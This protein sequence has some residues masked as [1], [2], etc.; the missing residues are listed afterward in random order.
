MV[1]PAARFLGAFAILAAVLLI[2]T[3][4][5]ALNQP[6]PPQPPMPNPNGYDDFVKAGQ[7]LA[8]LK[9]N[10][11]YNTMGQD[12]LR[13]VVAANSE[14]LKLA[15]T[16]LSRECRFPLE[17]STTNNISLS[18]LK[19][20][21]QAF[22]A[23]GRLAQLENR[24]GDAAKSY[25]DTMRLGCQ[26]SR[27]GRLIEALVSVAI[28]AIGATHLEKLVF[29]LDAKQCREAAAALEVAD[30]QRAATA[31]LLDQE[32]EWARRTYGIKGQVMRLVSYKSVKQ[33]EKGCATKIATQQARTWQLMI[34]LAARAYELDR[35]QR[36]KTI[37]EL[38]PAY[39]K[40]I[41]FNPV[42]GT[43]MVYRP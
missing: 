25:S 18:A 10:Q 16:G 21:A 12:E 43:N 20:L 9:S 17:Y 13:T 3:F 11:D 5:W 19:R 33:T 32:S 6:L 24:P 14:A 1:P 37:E 36:P 30:G 34:D 22:A 26:T 15:R 27:G 2:A 23:E 41:P 38:V 8:T 31:A 40:A 29:S 39:L 35:G 42:T 28:E 7:M 4:I